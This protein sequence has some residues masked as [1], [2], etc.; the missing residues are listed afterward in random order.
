MTIIRRAFVAALVGFACACGPT[1]SNDPATLV[2]EVY[3]PYMSEGS[4]A[5]DWRLAVPMTPDLAALVDQNDS[6]SGGGVGAIDVDPIIA[7]QDY[8]LS[9]LVVS[10]ENPPADGAAVVMARF[11]NFGEPT[12]VHFEMVNDAGWRVNNI[13]SGDYDL[14][15]QLTPAATLAQ[16]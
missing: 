16:E 6:D 8:Q 3:Q 9:N 1:A 15:E 5:P 7:A 10:V 14:R 12:T 11:D 2:M 4:H 13:R